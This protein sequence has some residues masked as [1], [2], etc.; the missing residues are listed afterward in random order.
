MKSL[1]GILFSSCHYIIH[2]KVVQIH[3]KNVNII[4]VDIFVTHFRK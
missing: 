2:T 3:Q 4:K 1:D